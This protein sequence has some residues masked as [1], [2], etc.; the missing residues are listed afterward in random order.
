M[1]TNLRAHIEAGAKSIAL[2]IPYFEELNR[3]NFQKLI[4]LSTRG[5]DLLDIYLIDDGSRDSLSQLISEVIK[6][7]SLLN[8]FQV[9]SKNNLGKANAIRFGYNSITHLQGKYSYFGFTDADFSTPPA[10]IIRV[11]N[12]VL[13]A[14]DK[15]IYGV[16]IPTGSNLIQTSKFRS[17]QGKFFTSIVS[18]ILKAPFKDSQCGLKFLRINDKTQEIF[19]T[20]FVNR[21]LVDLEI[22]SRAMS[23]DEICVTEIVLH[24]WT[25]VEQSK[26]GIRDVPRVAIALLR[27]RYKYGKMSGIKTKTLFHD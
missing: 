5:R 15:F 20:P 22:I 19:S 26:T 18:L 27:L 12:Y 10:E 9:A 8:V 6:K 11:A 23:N 24:E 17:T 3:F 1:K 25:H 7:N 13:A 16:R 4:E 14:G 21:W 2:V